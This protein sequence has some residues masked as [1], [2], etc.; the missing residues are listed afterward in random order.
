[1]KVTL[2][3]DDGCLPRVEGKDIARIVFEAIKTNPNWWLAAA[4]Q[5]TIEGSFG[6]HT[7][8]R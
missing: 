7:E 2:D 6:R 3:I 1:M 4:D 8:T 5:V